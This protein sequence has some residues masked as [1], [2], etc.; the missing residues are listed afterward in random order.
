M[1]SDDELV[2]AMSSAQQYAWMQEH[3]PALFERVAGAG[4]GR[5]G[6]CRSAACGW[7]RTPTCPAARRWPGSSCTASGSSWSEFGVETERGVAAGL[8]RLLRGAAADHH[9]RRLA[10]VPHPEDL[11][12]PD[13]RVPHHTFWLGGHRRHPD[14][15]PLPA[16]RHLQRRAVRA[17]SWPSR[18]AGSPRRARAN[19]RW[20]RSAGAT[21]AAG[22]PGRCWPRRP[23][24][25]RPGG[26]ADGADRA[27]RRSSSPRPR[28]STRTP[29]VWVGELYLELHRGTYTTQAGPSAATGAASTCCAR[30]SCG[31]PRP[32]CAPAPRTRTRS[33]TGSGETVLL[34]Q[35]HD[36]LPGS[37][38]AW[39]HRRPSASTRGSAA[40][41]E[42]LIDATRSA[43]STGPG[44]RELAVNA[45]PVR[46]WT[47]CPALGVAAG[48]RRAA[49]GRRR[50]DARRRRAGQRRVRVRSTTAACS[51]RCSTWPPTARCSPRRAG[52]PAAAA[53]RHP[54]PAGTPGT[55]TSTTGAPGATWSRS[56][57]LT[58]EPTAPVRARSSARPARRRSRS[59]CRC[60]PAHRWSTSSPRSTGTSGRSCSRSRSRWTCTPTG[61]RPRPSSGTCTGRPHTNT[62]WDAARFETCAHR[63][64]HVG[65]PGYGVAVVNDATYG[66]DVT[67]TTRPGGGTTTTVRL[68]LLRAPLFP[69][70]DTDQGPHR[71]AV[72][73][74]AGRDDRRRGR[75][76]LPAQPAAA[77]GPR[78]RPVAPLVT[79]DHRRSWS[80][81]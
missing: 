60:A 14:L 62:T 69:D 30:P 15:H 7:S 19:R 49:T 78:R 20:C 64:V 28:R 18:S 55:S 22:R 51:S 74:R 34:H 80:R 59:G 26:L 9:G 31:R 29:P 44:E 50:R 68:S 21:A 61:P 4:R 13:E 77:P 17:R 47:G 24:P 54:D 41:L 10:L 36:I 5:A 45:G 65:E 16:G 37:S 57:T 58:V 52:Q 73:L 75:R 63:W 2:F 71:F 66:H 67:R 72:A 70:P 53:P 33:W 79:V 56:T 35:F 39:V 3:H 38:I 43:R 32:R 76:G 23:G 12:E 81:R 8:V 1:D 27:R 48:R 46:R 6:S 11:L 40:E 25:G 42:A